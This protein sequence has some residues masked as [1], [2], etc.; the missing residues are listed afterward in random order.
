VRYLKEILAFTIGAI[1]LATLI[2][3]PEVVATTTS[4]LVLIAFAWHVYASWETQIRR[5]IAGGDHGSRSSSEDEA[6]ANAAASNNTGA[7]ET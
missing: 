5:F 6:G 2:A 3:P 1:W 4:T 7:E